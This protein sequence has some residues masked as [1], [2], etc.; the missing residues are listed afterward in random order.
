MKTKVNQFDAFVKAIKQMKIEAKYEYKL[1]L[2]LK[3]FPKSRSN[4]YKYKTL[5]EVLD[6]ASAF[7]VN[8]ID[9]SND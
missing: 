1:A 6:T 8:N 4:F 9:F 3:D 5:C 2:D 7:T